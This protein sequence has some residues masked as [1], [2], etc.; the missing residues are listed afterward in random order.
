MKRELQIIISASAA[1]VLPFSALAQEQPNPPRNGPDYRMP[2]T[3]RAVGIEFRLSNTLVLFSD[4]AMYGRNTVPTRYCY[5]PVLGSFFSR[6][7]G[8]GHE[9]CPAG[10]FV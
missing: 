7:G 8:M 9:A 5:A 4:A 10:Q 6:A 1:A 2:H 3:Q